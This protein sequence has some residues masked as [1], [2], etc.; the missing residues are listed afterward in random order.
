VTDDIAIVREALKD[1]HPNESFE[2]T[3]GR[4]VRRQ[5]GTFSDYLRIADALR[6]LA[7]ERKVGLEDAARAFVG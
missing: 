5:G 2:R 7:R 3:L 6:E 1:R 4:I